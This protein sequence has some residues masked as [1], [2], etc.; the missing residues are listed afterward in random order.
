MRALFVTGLIPSVNTVYSR[1]NTNVGG[2]TRDI[3]RNDNNE[4]KIESAV[5]RPLLD[6]D[7]VLADLEAAEGRRQRQ[8]ARK[9]RDYAQLTKTVAPGKIQT[10]AP[11][12]RGAATSPAPKKN[13]QVGMDVTIDGLREG[14][15]IF[16]VLSEVVPKTAQNFISLCEGVSGSG[17]K[18]TIFHRILPHFMVQG[19]DI[20]MKEGDGGRSIYG[21]IFDDENFVVKH[22]QAG[23]LSM[24]NAGPNTNGSQFFITTVPTPWLDGRHVAFGRI[25]SGQRVLKA[26]ENQGTEPL[27][28]PRKEV[29]MSKCFLQEKK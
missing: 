3:R 23:V 7:F 5:H 27:G 13:Y 15:M 11:K 26:M 25:V 1:E 2:P 6:D 4:I 19:G 9:E 28:Q 14:T 20:D 18:N 8:M 10:Q 29:K 12:I 24:A 16:D 17:Y 22:D 21:Q